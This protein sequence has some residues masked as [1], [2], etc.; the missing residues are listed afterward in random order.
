MNVHEGTSWYMM[1]HNS[2]YMMIHD[3]TCSPKRPCIV[4]ENFIEGNMGQLPVVCCEQ[5]HA[6]HVLH[7]KIMLRS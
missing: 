2:A 7:G 4:L 5:S 6:C 3:G 1:V